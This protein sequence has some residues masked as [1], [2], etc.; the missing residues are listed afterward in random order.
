MSV[1][2]AR[3]FKKLSSPPRKMHSFFNKI[4]FALFSFIPLFVFLAFFEILSRL[5]WSPPSFDIRTPSIEVLNY[6]DPATIQ[7]I[8]TR[9]ERIGQNNSYAF[10]GRDLDFS[11]SEKEFVIVVLG[12]LT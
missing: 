7:E 6:Y 1:P 9:R 11:K 8:K 12:G 2:S 10:R 5:F 4:K 3:E